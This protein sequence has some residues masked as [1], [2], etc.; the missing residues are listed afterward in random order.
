MQSRS[1]VE[2]RRRRAEQRRVAKLG[3]AAERRGRATPVSVAGFTDAIATWGNGV[4]GNILIS[5]SNQ[6]FERL[7]LSSS[8]MQAAALP[9]LTAY[10]DLDVSLETLGAGSRAPVELVRSVG[11]GAR[12]RG[13]R[14]AIRDVRPDDRGMRRCPNST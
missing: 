1:R 3:G 13:N 12:Q 8:T 7:A 9:T 14:D 6:R 10:F 5:R 11:L 4:L 2:R